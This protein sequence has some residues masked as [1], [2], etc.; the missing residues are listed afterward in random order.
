MQVLYYDSIPAGHY[1]G[2]DYIDVDTGL[3][4]RGYSLDW[5][6]NCYLGLFFSGLLW[7]VIALYIMLTSNRD[8]KL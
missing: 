5:V 3:D 7:H 4:P 1:K 2:E 6:N 8:K